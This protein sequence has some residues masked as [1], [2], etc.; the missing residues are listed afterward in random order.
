MGDAGSTAVPRTEGQAA[1]PGRPDVRSCSCIASGGACIPDY[2]APT[3]F[4]CHICACP[5][6]PTRPDRLA[7]WA[8]PGPNSTPLKATAHAGTV[9]LYY[10]SD[11][12][13][14][15]RTR[16]GRVESRLGLVG[17]FRHFHAFKAA[18]Q[19]GWTDLEIEILRP[20]IKLGET[21]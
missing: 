14:L 16:G 9:D 21:F 6:S 1:R 10:T 2:C 15:P 18:H 19:L 13:V 3:Q 11:K 17:L 5:A 20:G 12:S 4:R 8:V 7:S